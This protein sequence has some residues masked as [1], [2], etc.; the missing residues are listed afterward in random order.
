MVI[1]INTIPD[2]LALGSLIFLGLYINWT[3]WIEDEVKMFI[4]NIL[5]G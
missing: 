5:G 3:F 2:L 4:K 1:E